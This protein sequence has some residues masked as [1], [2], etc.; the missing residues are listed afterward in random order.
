MK[1]LMIKEVIA[2]PTLD[3]EITVMGWVRTRRG[4]KA[5]SFIA[6]NDGSCI[7]NLQIVADLARFSPEVMQQITTGASLAVRGP[8]VAS[9]G[10]G[11]SIEFHTPHCEQK[12]CHLGYSAPH[13][14]QW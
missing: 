8:L 13:S 9:Q 4:N 6:L 1:R 11:Q 3:Q 12:P 2:S 5:V 14:V 7:H 10:A